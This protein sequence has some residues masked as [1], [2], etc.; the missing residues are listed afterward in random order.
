MS[1][2]LIL[3]ICLPFIHLAAALLLSSSGTISKT[4]EPRKLAYQEE[5]KL[6]DSVQISTRQMDITTP[7]TTV[8]T[9]TNPTL[10]PT[11]SNPESPL[12]MNPANPVMTPLATNS[13][14]SSTGS[15]CVASR[16]VS[17]TAL[18]S[19]LDYACGQG[20]ADCS[21]IQADGVCYNPNT[22]RDHAS[23]AFNSYFQ[24]NPIPTSCNFG[25][26]AVTTS[27][28]PSY[29]A[30]R[31]PSTSTSSS[32]LNTT[33]SSGSRVFGAGRPITPSTSTA[34]TPS[35]RIPYYHDALVLTVAIL[36]AMP[37]YSR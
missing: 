19:A 11:D 26:V 28:D 32:V 12:I 18:Q 36:S 6:Q 34:A 24:N 3:G 25:G 30:C 23:Y 22:V 10:N 37:W 7:I 31:Y 29:G 33:N 2:R 20:G 9:T 5:R 35:S 8:P 1:R 13:P 4:T 17:Q 27:T 21:A 16:S 14:A 15:W